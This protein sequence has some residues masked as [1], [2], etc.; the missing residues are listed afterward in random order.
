MF[1]EIS[2]RVRNASPFP[3]TFYFGYAN[4]WIGYLPTGKAFG[5]GGYEPKTSVFTDRAEKD[6]GD[7]VIGYLQ[8]LERR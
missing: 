7:A 8:S 5:E 4:G 6:V 1:C 2:M 3:H